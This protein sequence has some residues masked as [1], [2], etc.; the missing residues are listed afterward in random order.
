MKA[1][2]DDKIPYIKGEIERIIPDS[3]YIPGGRIAA[4]DV[5][6]ADVLIVRTRTRCDKELLEGSQVRLIVTAT[7]GHDHIDTEW[8]DSNGIEWRNCPGCN[9]GSVATYV[10]NAL[11]VVRHRSSDTGL[12][13]PTIGV[14]G[15]GHVGSKVAADSEQAGFRIL[16][17]DPLLGMD[18]LSRII[19]EADVITFHVPL[20]HTGEHPTYHMADKDF[21][22]SLRRRP[23]IINTSRG[24]IVD[25]EALL[26]AMDEDLV[27]GCVIDTWENEPAIN[28]RLLQKALIATPH[29]AGYSADGKLNATRMT[30][31][32]VAAWAGVTADLGNLARLHSELRRRLSPHCRISP[33]TII[34][35]SELLKSRPHDF[36]DFRGNYPQRVE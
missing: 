32:T 27:S 26:S 10:R 21:F 20:T 9:A 14:I 17:H 31:Q 1:I 15:H 24:G 18:N 28:R 16:C 5:R 19:D 36:E 4:S 33:D 30:L 11:A 12:T 13:R 23:L 29:I 34:S 2:L 6:D 3:S 35:D 7:I 8:C 22:R 25:E